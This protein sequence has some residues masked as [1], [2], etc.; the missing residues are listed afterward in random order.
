[1][2]SSEP[3]GHEAGQAAWEMLKKGFLLPAGGWTLTFYEAVRG[4][5]LCSNP[6]PSYTV[7]PKASYLTSLSLRFLI[8]RMGTKSPPCKD[9]SQDQAHSSVNAVC[10]HTPMAS[11]VN[12]LRL[13]GIPP[14]RDGEGTAAV[15]TGFCLPFP[16]PL[17]PISPLL[18][19]GRLSLLSVPRA[20]QA[21]STSGEEGGASPERP[22][23]E[24]DPQRG[25]SAL[26]LREGPGKNLV[27]KRK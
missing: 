7:Q 19:S 9:D 21:C 27:L 5:G 26:L 23:F 4:T 22:D 11:A 15:L 17:V 16:P 24:G 10:E 8:C 2:K 20:D 25:G 6:A 13:W 3:P 1:M 12:T 14:W 18:C